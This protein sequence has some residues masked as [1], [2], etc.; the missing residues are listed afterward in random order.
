M[1]E[2]IDSQKIKKREREMKVK[3]TYY[4]IENKCLYE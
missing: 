3:G 2:E 1:G 4:H